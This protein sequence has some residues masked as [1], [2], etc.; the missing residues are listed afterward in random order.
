MCQF[1]LWKGTLHYAFLR[2]F[3]HPISLPQNEFL[4]HAITVSCLKKGS[5][6]S[7]HVVYESSHSNVFHIT[8]FF[9]LRLSFKQGIS[10]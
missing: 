1:L 4:P 7:F 3:K 9:P 10:V 2:M 8:G 5:L 6:P